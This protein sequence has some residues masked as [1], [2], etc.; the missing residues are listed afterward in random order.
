MLRKMIYSLLE[1]RRLLAGC[2]FVVLL[3][4]LSASSCYSAGAMDD[5]T[6]DSALTEDS[7]EV[8]FSLLFAGDLLVFL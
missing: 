4:V 1:T 3:M 7:A 2:W 5:L 6:A 8:K